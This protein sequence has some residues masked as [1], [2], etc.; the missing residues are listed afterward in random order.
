MTRPPGLTAPGS[1]LLSVCQKF[2]VLGPFRFRNLQKLHRFLRR[3]GH[4][5]HE[6]TDCT[7]TFINSF[8]PNQLLNSSAHIRRSLHIVFEIMH[9]FGQNGVVHIPGVGAVEIVHQFPQRRI[10]AALSVHIEDV[11]PVSRTYRSM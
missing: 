11:G 4:A 5:F 10:A 7:Q 6:R 2:L 1:L 3:D 8:V 9:S